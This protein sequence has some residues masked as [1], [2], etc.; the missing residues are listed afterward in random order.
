MGY[1][2]CYSM[3]TY[4]FHLRSA[5]RE[6]DVHNIYQWPCLAFIHSEKALSAD[7]W[8]SVI[9]KKKNKHGSEQY[10]HELS[11]TLPLKKFPF[12]FGEWYAVG[13]L[14]GLIKSPNFSDI[15]GRLPIHF[16]PE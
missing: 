9:H 8:F 12:V 15:C 4:D 16:Y 11:L 3:I 14:S 10:H 6:V 13:L 2:Y 1:G 5:I 7:Q